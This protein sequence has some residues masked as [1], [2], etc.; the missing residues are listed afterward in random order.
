MDYQAGDSDMHKIVPNL[1]LACK[2]LTMMRIIILLREGTEFENAGWWQEKK[3][4]RKHNRFNG[5]AEEEVM[6]KSLPDLICPN[7]DILIVSLSSTHRHTHR[8][9]THIYWAR[10]RREKEIWLVF[11]GKEKFQL[12][13]T[14]IILLLL[15]CTGSHCSMG[16]L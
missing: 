16:K 15:L 9:D 12:L 8:H 11:N 13:F 3:P 7:L 5:M 2:V 10:N 1:H 6:K 14:V 4:R